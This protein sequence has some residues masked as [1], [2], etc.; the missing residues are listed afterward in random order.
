MTNWSRV[1]E[2]QDL[3]ESG[4]AAEALAAFRLIRESAA[5]AE[6]RSSILLHESLCY[7]DL[8]QFDKAAEATT[9]AIRLLSLENPSRLYA[10]FSLACVH[11]SE[12]KYDLAVKEFKTL[13]KNHAKR[14]STSEYV[15]FRRGVQFR[16]I[17][18]LIVL[19]HGLEPLSV[20]DSSRRRT[21]LRE[22]GLNSHIGRR[23]LINSS[24][25]T[26]SL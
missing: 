3:R 7:R 26:T 4:H 25:G 14:L 11:E 13:L 10:E 16:L 8:G 9:E 17:A 18:S 20:A 15:Q 12:G 21:F 2:I 24:D 22:S 23:R 5:D 1:R 6:D 19:G